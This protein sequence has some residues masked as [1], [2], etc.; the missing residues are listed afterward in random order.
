MVGGAN[1]LKEVDSFMAVSQVNA[2]FVVV[3]E[4]F[5]DLNNSTLHLRFEA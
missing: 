5:L 1:E 4:E 2:V 3:L